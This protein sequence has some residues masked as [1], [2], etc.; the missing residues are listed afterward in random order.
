MSDNAV[1]AAVSFDRVV[2]G[3][4]SSPESMEAARQGTLL[5]AEGASCYAVAAWDAALARRAGL[6]ADKAMAELKNDG[7]TALREARKALPTLEPVLVRGAPVPSLLS[8]AANLQANLISV[9]ARGT[10]RLAGIVLGSVATAMAHHAPCPVLIA[11]EVT[12]TSF[13]K[14]ILHAS[15]GSPESMSAAR[16]AGQLAA[17]QDA[18]VVMLTVSDGAARG[19]GIADEALAVTEAWGREPVQQTSEGSA[20]RRIVETADE[21]GAALVTM[22]G[23]GLT[24][25]RSLGS[26]SEAVVHGAP[27]SVLVVRGVAHPE[28]QDAGPP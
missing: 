3:V 23:R 2:C 10:S 1:D 20:H 12:R 11:R 24:G 9:G 17:R 15:D 4:D 8:A 27:C 7:E 5:A 16:V 14:L 28:S 6:Y 13:P 26:V 21:L 22:G 25:L 18:Q 19:G